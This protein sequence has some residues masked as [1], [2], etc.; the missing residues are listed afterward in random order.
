[1]F[2]FLSDLKSPIMLILLGVF[3]CLKWL[4]FFFLKSHIAVEIWRGAEC[5]H[6]L[7]S[8]RVLSSSRSVRGQTFKLTI[9]SLVS[10]SLCICG[11]DFYSNTCIIVWH[12]AGVKCKHGYDS[13]FWL[14]TDKI[15]L[16]DNCAM[17]ISQWFHRG[18]LEHE[19]N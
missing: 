8:Q 4:T 9:F 14:R 7:I 17:N 2:I 12:K 16:K 15:K 11:S 5:D 3:I 6:T 10:T 18:A 13:I 1:M 19:N